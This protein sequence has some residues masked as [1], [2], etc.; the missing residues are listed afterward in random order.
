MRVALHGFL[1]LAV[2]AG[3][4]QTGALWEAQQNRIL[5][6]ERAWN[7][8]VQQKDAKAVEPLLD[9][10][11]IYIDDDGTIMNKAHYLT[12]VRESAQHFQRIVNESTQVRFFGKSAVVIGIY[13]EQGVK[14]GKPYIL[15][16]RFVDTWIDQN[17]AWMC[18]ASQSTLIAH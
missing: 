6:L 9:E 17:N 12:S 14:N 11:L 15:R 4:A 8:A 1:L 3:N 13:R 16:D 5:A 18:V 7:Q 2:L 10:E